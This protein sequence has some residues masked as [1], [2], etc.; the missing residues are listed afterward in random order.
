MKERME[1]LLKSI[2][3]GSRV[4]DIGCDHGY[5]L[6]QGIEA[7]I[8]K[9]G[10]GVEVVEGPY[11]R[12]KTH[13]AHLGDQ[14]DIRL[15]SGLSPLEKGDV[16]TLVIAGMGGG[17][18][19]DILK[20]DEKEG[21]ILQGI[22]RLILQPMSAEEGVRSYLKE[23]GFTLIDETLLIDKK[24]YVFMVWEKGPWE[25]D[26]PFLL[27]A[28]PLLYERRHELGQA[29]KN[30]VNYRIKGLEQRIEGLKK[31]SGTQEKLEEA[32]KEKREWEALSND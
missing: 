22:H 13:T 23:R 28:G 3:R 26:D 27:K 18:I 31:G 25:W 20:D 8:I 11:Q 6:I 24:I 4:G 30:Y 15:G 7:G 10:I 21:D 12:A 9:K 5:L 14:I 16:D 19:V 17:T 2:K 1:E 29:W 32:Q